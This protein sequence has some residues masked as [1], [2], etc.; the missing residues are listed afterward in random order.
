MTNLA[1]TEQLM[2]LYGALLSGD[3]AT[4]ATLLD[5]DFVVRSPDTLP[6]GGTGHGV[7]GL[8]AMLGGFGQHWDDPQF[9]I[10]EF[11]SNDDLVVAHID[12]KATSKRTGG[13]LETHVIETWRLRE[14]KFT[15]M[16]A[17]YADPGSAAALL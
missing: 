11:T 8:G 12:L 5:D 9:N 10:R 7:A 4:V 3:M 1:A 14:G 15:E 6:Y 13:V 2:A 16:R 17:F